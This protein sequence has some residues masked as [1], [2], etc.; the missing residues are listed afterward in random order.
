MVSWMKNRLLP[1]LLLVALFLALPLVQAEAV[2]LSSIKEMVIEAP[3]GTVYFIYTDVRHTGS[4]ET[5]YDAVAGGILY[6]MCTQEQNQ[7]FDTHQYW[8][9]QKDIP[10]KLN[11]SGKTVVVLGGRAANWVTYYYEWSIFVTP[12]YVYLN[13]EYY[14]LITNSAVTGQPTQVYSIRI[15]E[16]SAGH[17]DMFVIESFKDSVG[18]TIFI[19]YGITWRGTWAG[20]IYFKDRL[21]PDIVQNPAN[22]HGSYF[23]GIWQDMPDQQGY[24]DGVPQPEEIAP[25]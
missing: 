5:A 21:Y 2:Q 11:L 10:G 7:G 6:S 24:L 4:P 8:V 20:G 14:Y 1:A 13:S 25:Y 12:M 18:N 3:K 19:I 22:Y 15:S 23:V 16:V 17:K 9:E